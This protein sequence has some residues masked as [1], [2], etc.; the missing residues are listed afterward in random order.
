MVWDLVVWIRGIPFWKGLL[1]R[2]PGIPNHQFTIFVDCRRLYQLFFPPWSRTVEFSAEACQQR[3]QVLDDCAHFT[4]WP[5]GGCLLTAEISYPKA[6]FLNASFP[7]PFFLGKQNH[8]WAKLRNFSGWKFPTT[9]IKESIFGDFPPLVMSCHQNFSK[10]VSMDRHDSCVLGVF[11]SSGPAFWNVNS[12]FSS[13][14]VGMCCCVPYRSIG[15]LETK[16]YLKNHLLRFFG[17]DHATEVCRHGERP[18]ILW[19]SRW[20]RWCSGSHWWNL[21]ARGTRQ[22]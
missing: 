20:W 13:S 15:L 17:P 19:S 4:F 6:I 2:A 12:P 8:P 18:E 9:K 7:T 22:W 5:D 16:N 1:L 10:G 14:T 21:R 11:P 3:C